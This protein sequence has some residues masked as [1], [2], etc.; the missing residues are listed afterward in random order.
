MAE[1]AKNSLKER[2][3]GQANAYRAAMEIDRIKMD[4]SVTILNEAAFAQVEKEVRCRGAL[5]C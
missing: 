4:H 2:I 1:A 5:D 3:D